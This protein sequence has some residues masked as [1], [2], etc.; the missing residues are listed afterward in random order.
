MNKIVINQA[1]VTREKDVYTDG[2]KWAFLPAKDMQMDIK[3]H[4]IIKLQRMNDDQYPLES[5]SSIFLTFSTDRNKLA[6]PGLLKNSL[7]AMN[8]VL[9]S[10]DRMV[11]SVLCLKRPS[12]NTPETVE[13]GLINTMPIIGVDDTIEKHS[14][15]LFHSKIETILDDRYLTQVYESD[16]KEITQKNK[17]TDIATGDIIRTQYNSRP[18]DGKIQISIKL[19]NRYNFG[20]VDNAALNVLVPMT[21]ICF[22]N[23][24]Q[25]EA[26]HIQKR[27]NRNDEPGITVYFGES[28]IS[29]WWWIYLNVGTN[30]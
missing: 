17:Y 18:L 15:I 2:T 11:E 6:L 27:I 23:M 21:G 7:D 12:N 28:R 29:K 26:L 24:E 5:Q 1:P 8:R 10:D 4:L 20:D 19:T 30:N 13:I 3:N 25:I 16:A 9:I 22:N 14:N